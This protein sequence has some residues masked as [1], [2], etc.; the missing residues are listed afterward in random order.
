MAMISF[1]QGKVNEAENLYKEA[2]RIDPGT[3]ESY[4][5]LG[6]VYFKGGKL[7]ESI[8]VNQEAIKRFP[9]WTEP[10]QNLITIY[11]SKK[12]TLS[13]QRVMNQMPK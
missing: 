1:N 8:N 13:A 2:I 9:Q 12:D 4:S 6:Y 11:L 7:D 10:Y 3:M 5:G